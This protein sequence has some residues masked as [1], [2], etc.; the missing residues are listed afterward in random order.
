MLRLIYTRSILTFTASLKNIRFI[1]RADPQEF[2]NVPP[3][4]VSSGFRVTSCLDKTFKSFSLV[5]LFMFLD[6]FYH[7]MNVNEGYFLS[8]L[9]WKYKA[10]K[11]PT[12]GVNCARAEAVKFK[13]RDVSLEA[14]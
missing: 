13:T 5:N 3:S 14:R 7:H 12:A 9:R 10:D 2:K 4:K 1:N 6:S 11:N 8:C